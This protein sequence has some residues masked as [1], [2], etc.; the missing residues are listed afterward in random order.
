MNTFTAHAVFS[1]TQKM[2]AR[3]TV[4]GERSLVRR[5]RRGRLVLPVQC[6]GRGAWERGR[7]GGLRAGERADGRLVVQRERRQRRR[8]LQRRRNLGRGI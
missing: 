7:G 5:G 2:R 1:M 3:L 6:G 4:G 8:Q